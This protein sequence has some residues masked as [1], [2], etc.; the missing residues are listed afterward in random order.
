LSAGAFADTLTLTPPTGGFITSG[1]G[2][3]RGDIITMTGDFTLTSIGIQALIAN[4]MQLTFNA[5]VYDDQS[6]S[7]VHQLA[8]GAPVPF[9][10]DGIETWFD[11]PISFTLMA[12]TSYD[13]GISFNSFNDPNLQIHYYSFSS[14]GNAPFVVGPVTVLDGEESHCGSCNV[15]TPNLRLNG[16]TAGVPEPGTLV[17]LGMGIIGLAGAF[18]RK[19]VG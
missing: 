3:T 18:R 10:G 5:Y 16:T 14:G 12:G 11:L 7:G 15:L 2:G 17:L 4:G 1:A 8:I 13:I 6:G 9:T 19:F